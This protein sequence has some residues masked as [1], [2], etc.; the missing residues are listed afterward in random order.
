M[1]QLR[2]VFPVTEWLLFNSRTLWAVYW[3]PELKFLYLIREE[4][5]INIHRN[6]NSR[7]IWVRT[8]HLFA[9][10]SVASPAKLVIHVAVWRKLWPRPQSVSVAASLPREKWVC[11]ENL[12]WG[13]LEDWLG[14]LW[15]REVAR[16]IDDV[17]REWHGLGEG[18]EVRAARGRKE[19]RVKGLNK[20]KWDGW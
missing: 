12:L 17:K 15:L 19:M 4:N 6:R 9:C 1:R 3:R 7:N 18:K 16:K 20:R 11:S 2:I 8:W 13:S 10:L 5:A 14:F